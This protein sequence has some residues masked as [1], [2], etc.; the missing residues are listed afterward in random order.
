MD[1]NIKT[2]LSQFLNISENITDCVIDFE[3]VL[4]VVHDL[5]SYFFN[6]IYKTLIIIKVVQTL[7]FSFSNKASDERPM[8]LNTVEC[9]VIVFSIF[10][11]LILKLFPVAFLIRFQFL[12]S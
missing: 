11:V 9:F 5:L 8:G 10:I 2:R 4:L 7:N 6:H 12:F 3:S 1:D